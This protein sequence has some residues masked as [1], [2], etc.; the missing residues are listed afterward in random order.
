MSFAVTYE[1]LKAGAYLRE[2][3]RDMTFAEIA[4]SLVVDAIQSDKM[5]AMAKELEVSDAELS[6]AIAAVIDHVKADLWWTIRHEY[7]L[8][9]HGQENRSLQRSFFDSDL[10]G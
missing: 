4:T 8:I 9:E 6:A 5:V 7:E 10:Y 1:H 3:G 2:T